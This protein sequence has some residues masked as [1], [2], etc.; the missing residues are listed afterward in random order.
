MSEPSI[1]KYQ[2]KSAHVN[3]TVYLDVIVNPVE[4]QKLLWNVSEEGEETKGI[5]L[6]TYSSKH[7]EVLLA[8]SLC[9]G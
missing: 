5:W 2:A 3:A 7:T 9:Q 1:E 4:Y 8:T 6:W